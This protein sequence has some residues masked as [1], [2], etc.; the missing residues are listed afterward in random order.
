MTLLITIHCWEIFCG[1]RKKKMKCDSRCKSSSWLTFH[2]SQQGTRVTRYCRKD[3]QRCDD[4][5][6]SG[7]Q[8]N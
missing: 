7:I 5:K 1:F 4:P 8:L 3:R 6:L 2:L